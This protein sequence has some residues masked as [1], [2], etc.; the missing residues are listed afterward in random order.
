MTTTRT[1][2][3]T[4]SFFDCATLA[5]EAPNKATAYHLAYRR[6]GEAYPKQWAVIIRVDRRVALGAPK[7][8]SRADSSLPEIAPL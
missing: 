6:Y 1:F 2:T 7:R 8:R 3:Y 4:V 5:V